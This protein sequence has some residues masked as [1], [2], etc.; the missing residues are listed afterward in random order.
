MSSG[1]N[2]KESMFANF[3]NAVTD[4]E[5]QALQ[6]SE[7]VPT[8]DEFDSVTKAG[9]LA[10]ESIEKP[11][12]GLIP[13]RLHNKKRVQDIDNAICRY[14]EARKIIPEEWIVERNELI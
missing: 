14:I 1:E 9:G 8:L 7:F 3:R 6:G 12:L 4:T 5:H 13:Q 10:R 2:V 11:P